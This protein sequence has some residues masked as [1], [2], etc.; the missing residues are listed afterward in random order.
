MVS[1]SLLGKSECVVVYV[2]LC[3][4][5]LLQ[6]AAFAFEGLAGTSLYIVALLV[7]EPHVALKQIVSLVVI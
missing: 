5:T 6:H 4:A 7:K 1:W 2:V 3:I